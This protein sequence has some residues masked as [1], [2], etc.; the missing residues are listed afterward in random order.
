MS[1]GRPS[2]FPVEIEREA[3]AVE[4][5]LARVSVARPSGASYALRPF[6]FAY[7]REP[8]VFA[9]VGIGAALGMTLLLVEFAWTVVYFTVVARVL[10]AFFFFVAVSLATRFLAN[11]GARIEITSL[12]GELVVK[13]TIFGRTRRERRYPTSQIV[14]VR[15]ERGDGNARVVL[16]GPRHEVLGELYRLRALDPEALA[17]WMAEMCAIVARRGTLRE[18]G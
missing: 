7:R 9:A 15:V 4:A 14:E 11:Y 13:Q 2:R 16:A 10:A 17:S 6:G 3:S 18:I 8:D 1:K 12:A 5:E